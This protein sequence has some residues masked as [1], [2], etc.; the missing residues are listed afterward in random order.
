MRND[1][2]IEYIKGYNISLREVERS[3]LDNGENG[4]QDCSTTIVGLQKREPVLAHDK[5]PDSKRGT[6]RTRHFVRVHR[7]FLK[8]R[9]NGKR[10]GSV[11]KRIHYVGRVMKKRKRSVVSPNFAL[12][13]DQLAV[14]EFT[15]GIPCFN[16]K[17]KE[18]PQQC[19][20]YVTDMYQYMFE[21]EV[22]FNSI[23]SFHP[24]LHCDN[25]SLKL[26]D[27][28]FFHICSLKKSTHQYPYINNIQSISTNLRAI[29][30]DWLTELT[31][32]VSQHPNTLYLT[33]SL[34][35]RYCA[36]VHVEKKEVQLIAVAA[37]F[38]A[39][40]Y[41]EVY[42]V[43]NTATLTYCTDHSFTKSDIIVMEKTIVHELDWRLTVPTAY[44]FLT[45]FLSLVDTSDFIKNASQYYIE[46]VLQEHAMLK[47]SPS[48]ISC[49]A[50]VL[51]LNNDRL[52]TSTVNCHDE[53]HVVSVTIMTNLCSHVNNLKEDTANYTVELHRLPKVI[54]N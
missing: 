5:K 6:S 24:E 10:R 3:F 25:P 28:F 26:L 14:H 53:P 15:H 13:R 22:C 21:H 29:I 33:V 4:A 30:V 32:V 49:A 41:E 12:E 8:R 42:S 27:T 39:S 37:L 17:G 45:I 47:Y 40:K 16:M 23:S 11:Y 44:S 38:I 35:D 52:D 1:N 50:V 20:D 31:N 7:T 36:R 19:K 54:I 48:Q 43:P 9:V 2:L 46:R 51:A 34:F 18:D